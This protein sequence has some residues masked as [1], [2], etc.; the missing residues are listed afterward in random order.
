MPEVYAQN[1]TNKNM[2]P[3]FGW[4]IYEKKVTPFWT[5][6]W[7]DPKQHLPWSP[8]A[9][10]SRGLDLFWAW[11]LWC[12]KTVWTCPGQPTRRWAKGYISGIGSQVGMHVHTHLGE[13]KG[14]FPVEPPRVCVSMML[15]SPAFLAGTRCV[16]GSGCLFHG[17]SNN[18][19][20]FG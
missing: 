9:F 11:T 6:F 2:P 19:G 16:P 15:E 8:L 18:P 13:Q 1:K 20:Q 17:N 12:G 4:E 7:V 5:A 14:I 3:L 10:Q